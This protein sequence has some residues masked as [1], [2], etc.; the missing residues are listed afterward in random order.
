MMLSSNSQC[1]L[2]C[3]ARQVTKHPLTQLSN[4]DDDDEDYNNSNDDDALLW[5]PAP[6]ALPSKTSDKTPTDTAQQ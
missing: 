6:T 3:L 2:L 1:W 4:D 5:L